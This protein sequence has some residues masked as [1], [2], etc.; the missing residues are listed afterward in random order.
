MQRR[1]FKRG[2]V[3]RS[4]ERVKEDLMAWSENPRLKFVNVFHDFLTAIPPAYSEQVLSQQ[5][6]L[7]LSYDFFDLPTKEQLEILLGSFLGGKIHFCLAEKHSATREPVDISRLIQR[8]WQA[9]SSGKYEVVLTYVKRFLSDGEYGKAF[10]SVV[11]ETK[12][13]PCQVDYWWEDF[14]VPD[15][16]G[17]G[18]EES[19]RACLSWEHKYSYMNALFR[20]GVLAYRYAPSLTKSLS[21]WYFS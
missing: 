14:P 8:I 7:H 18:S 16:Q 1:L 6:K 12:V 13:S 5:Y 3:L 20:S 21:H 11:K 17:V 15:E 2:F 9:Q 10:H 4:A 19:Y